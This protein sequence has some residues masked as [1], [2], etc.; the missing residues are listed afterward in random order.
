MSAVWIRAQEFGQP[1]TLMVIGVSK[2]GSRFSSSSMVAGPALVS[3]IASL[4]NSMPV[5]AIVCPPET[6]GRTCRSERGQP[7]TSGSTWSSARPGSSIF[8]SVV[9]RTRS[10]PWASATSAILARVVP[11]TRPTRGAKPT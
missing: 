9:V 3:T 2:S 1:L 6:L 5:Q 10:E 7:A 8:C 4:Q 11:S